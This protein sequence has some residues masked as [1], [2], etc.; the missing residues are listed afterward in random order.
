[1]INLK[2]YISARSHC[3]NWPN[4]AISSQMYSLFTTVNSFDKFHHVMSLVVMVCGRHCR[5]ALYPGT[6]SIGT[7]VLQPGPGARPPPPVWFGSEYQKPYMIYPHNLH[8]V[9]AVPAR[10]LRN[11][12]TP[13]TTLP[14]PPKKNFGKSRL[15]MVE[16]GWVR[17]PTAL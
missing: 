1:M 16:I 4:C 9:Y 12:L 17:V 5:T 15:T 13:T 10:S 11:L 8:T 6:G 3:V 2:L 14:P 7:E